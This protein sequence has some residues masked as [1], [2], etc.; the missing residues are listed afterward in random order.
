MHLSRS[1]EAGCRSTIPL[2]SRSRDAPSGG[3]PRVSIRRS[4]TIVVGGSLAQKPGAGGHTWVFLQYLLGFRRLGWDVLFLDRL[5]PEMCVGPD[6][7][8]TSLEDSENLRYLRATLA[9]F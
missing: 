6:G 7:G 3:P 2:R 9:R 1:S 5:E 8:P 4:G